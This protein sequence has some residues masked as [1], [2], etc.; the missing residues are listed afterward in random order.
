MNQPPTFKFH[1]V[2]GP[3]SG[4]GCMI[5]NDNLEGMTDQGQPVTIQHSFEAPQLIQELLLAG[6]QNIP[7]DVPLSEGGFNVQ[8]QAIQSL[9]E[10]TIAAGKQAARETLSRFDFASMTGTKVA[11]TG[12]AQ[13]ETPYVDEVNQEIQNLLSGPQ[14]QQ[15]RIKLQLLTDALGTKFLEGWLLGKR[16]IEDAN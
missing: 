6:L 16:Q 15:V 1:I 13:P 9:L 3:A 10:Q 11:S 2:S 8:R 5:A 7:S 4:S 12:P 14:Q